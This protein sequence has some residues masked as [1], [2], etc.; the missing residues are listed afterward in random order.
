MPWLFLV[1]TCLASTNTQAQRVSSAH[2]ALAARAGDETNPLVRIG[3]S[4]PERPSLFS[5]RFDRLPLWSA[6]IASALVPGLGQARLH[7]DRFVTYMALEAYLVVQY[8]KNS[9][10]A[11]DNAGT[12]RQIARDV[13]RRGFPGSHPDT[14]WQYYEKMEKYDASGVFTKSLTG[15]TLPETDVQTYNGQQWVLA[16]QVYGIRLDDENA[17]ARPTYAQAV[18]YYESRAIP[19]AY[20]WNWVNASLE[21]DLFVRAI[22][23]SNDAS[24]RA[25]NDLIVLIANHIVS[26]VDAFSSIR[27]MQGADGT[28]RARASISVP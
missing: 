1:S 13:A 20:G 15:A 5:A 8:F 24:R 21:K 18:A 4:V 28:L 3:D 16:R 23:R 10:E 22:G 19:Q 14:V 12:Y 11:D 9:T 26:T 2:V 25:T 6:P 7:Q 17:S 27:L